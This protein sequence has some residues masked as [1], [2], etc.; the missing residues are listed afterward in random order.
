MARQDDL[1]Y[2]VGL[3]NGDDTAHYLA[4]GY[5]VV[6]IEANPIMVRRARERFED[7]IDRGR[8]TVIECGVAESD[9]SMTF[10]VSEND[11]WSSFD[12]SSASR[13]GTSATQP[14]E[15]V[16]RRFERLLAEHGAPYYLKVDIEARDHLCLAALPTL[17]SD[18]LPAYVSWE[19]GPRA[20]ERVADMADLGYRRFK[21]I[22]QT[23]HRAALT[24]HLHPLR[25]R[26]L[27]GARRRLH[28]PPTKG[29]EGFP[30]GSS[31]PFGEQTDGQ[32]QPAATV[33]EQ[34]KRY[35]ALPKPEADWHPWFDVHAAR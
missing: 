5:R 8:L 35:V 11:H 31:G 33:M 4:S 27:R 32:W 3:H 10:Y 24:E 21:V 23:D 15:V 28:L 1:V 22:R 34:W 26:V 30:A 13:D 25:T 17:P 9:G 14:L 2:D 20:H 29:P 19:A 18:D 7:E 6:A 16:T 12:L